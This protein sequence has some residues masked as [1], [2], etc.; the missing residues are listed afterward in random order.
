MSE[1]SSQGENNKPKTKV[2]ETWL[3]WVKLWESKI[4]VNFKQGGKITRYKRDQALFLIILKSL[5]WKH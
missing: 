3:H 1:N 5:S 2:Q 4:W